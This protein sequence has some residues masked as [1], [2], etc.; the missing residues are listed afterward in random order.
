MYSY[1]KLKSQIL[2]FRKNVFLAEIETPAEGGGG[3]LAEAEG[4]RGE[5]RV[6]VAGMIRFQKIKGFMGPLRLKFKNISNLM[7]GQVI[8]VGSRVSG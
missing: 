2:G 1:E 7:F 6:Q 5:L 4:G 3:G 8:E